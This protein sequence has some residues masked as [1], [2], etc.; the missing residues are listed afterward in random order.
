MSEPC[1]RTRATK[2]HENIF[3]FC[4]QN[5]TTL[6]NRWVIGEGET[7][8]TRTDITRALCVCTYSR[9]LLVIGLHTVTGFRLSKPLPETRNIIR[10]NS[11]YFGLE[12]NVLLTSIGVGNLDTCPKCVEFINLFTFSHDVHHCEKVMGPSSKC[13]FYHFFFIVCSHFYTFQNWCCQYP[14]RWISLNFDH[15]LHPS[16]VSKWA[17]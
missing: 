17:S 16:Y 7:D 10:L 6:R 9:S 5:T 2:L 12:E 13:I 11:C 1:C 4:W 14:S 8:I 3:Y 15:R